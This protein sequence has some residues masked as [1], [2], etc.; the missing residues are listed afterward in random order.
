VAAVLAPRAPTA[1]ARPSA[2]APVIS[3]QPLPVASPKTTVEPAAIDVS[4]KVD[5]VPK[6]ESADHP[7]E[8]IEDSRA[9]EARSYSTTYLEVGRFHDATWA[10]QTTSKLEQLGLRATVVRKGHFGINSYQVLVGPYSSDEDAKA[11]HKYLVSRGFTPRAYERG[12]RSFWFPSGL[13][14]HGTHIPGDDCVIRWESYV[15]DAVV[16]FEKDG[17]IVTT[18]EG[19]WVSRDV[20]YPWNAIVYQRNRD[21]SRTLLEIRF[22][23]MNR[24]LVFG[25]SS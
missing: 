19:R 6:P 11:A 13:T 1:I 10:D 24:V 5:A 8:H 12:S 15:T 14:L 25:A 18:A 17:S 16:K 22:E 21:G 20:K 2:T 4:T 9:G 23:G 3:S 7:S